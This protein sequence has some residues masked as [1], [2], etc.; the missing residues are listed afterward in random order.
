MPNDTLSILLVNA[1]GR[2]NGSVS[3]QLAADLTA[4][5]ETAGREIEIVER[6]LADGV[7]FVDEDWIG[8]NFTPPEQRTAQQAATLSYSD[9]LVEEMKAADVIVIATP[10]YNFGTPASLKAWIDQIARARLTFQYTEKGPVGLLKGKRAVIV[11]ASGGTEVGSPI[12][13]ATPYL[14]YV[15][16]FVGIDAVDIV[17]ADRLMVDAEAALAKAGEQIASLAHGIV[18]DARKAA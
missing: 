8:A 14:R 7:P 9:E 5:I 13:F 18:V 2:R 11:A 10:V 12:D 6:D 17:A 15:L 16:G 3:R 4:A 1:S